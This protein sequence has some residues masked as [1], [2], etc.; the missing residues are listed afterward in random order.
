MLQS[1]F[2][3]NTQLEFISVFFSVVKCLLAR[4]PKVNRSRTD[5]SRT[6]ATVSGKWRASPVNLGHSAAAFVLLIVR[7]VYIDRDKPKKKSFIYHV[8][9]PECPICACVLCVHLWVHF[10]RTGCAS[11]LVHFKCYLSGFFFFYVGAYLRTLSL[12]HDWKAVANQH[13]FL[14]MRQD[15]SDANEHIVGKLY[16]RLSGLLR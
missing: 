12:Q 8:L 9:W 7:S 16:L 2:P 11:R 4:C 3:Y 5:R 6:W 1:C 14:R 13:L 10:S 15:G